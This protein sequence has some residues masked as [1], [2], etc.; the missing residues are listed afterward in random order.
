MQI[1]SIFFL[2]KPLKEL[3]FCSY[4]SSAFHLVK[5]STPKK[6]FWCREKKKT[7]V[8]RLVFISGINNQ[9]EEFY[10]KGRVV[11]DTRTGLEQA[12]TKLSTPGYSR[13]SGAASCG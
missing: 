6:P 3:K 10:L 4:L 11:G 1:K 12:G 8:S 13:A 9:N 7:I 2:L 5:D